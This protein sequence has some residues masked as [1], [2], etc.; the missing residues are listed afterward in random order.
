MLE[1]RFHQHGRS[2][3]GF[4]IVGYLVWKNGERQARPMLEPAGAMVPAAVLSKLRYFVAITAPDSF[5]GLQELRSEFW[6]FVPIRA[7]R[8]PGG[9]A[10]TRK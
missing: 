2:Q 9:T 1:A 6:S 10:A 8:R 3:P 4:E 5:A 7:G